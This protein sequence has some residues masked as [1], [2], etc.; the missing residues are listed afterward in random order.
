[1]KVSADEIS[2]RARE[3]LALGAALVFLAAAGTFVALSAV[4]LS[5]PAVSAALEAVMTV[6]ALLSIVRLERCFGWS[7]ERRDLLLMAAV[8][9]VWLRDAPLEA[10][11]A[12][13]GINREDASDAVQVAMQ[14]LVVVSFLLAAFTP[15]RRLAASV[16]R[17]VLFSAL[18]VVAIVLLAGALDLVI[19]ARPFA[20]VVHPLHHLK[21]GSSVPEIAWISISSALLVAAAAGLGARASRG[22]AR[23]APFAAAA[24]LM[25]VARLQAVAIPGS[26]SAWVTVGDGLR[27]LAYALVLWGASARYQQALAARLLSSSEVDVDQLEH[28]ASE[29][30]ARERQRLARDL[31]DGLAQ[32]LAVIALHAQQLE[33]RL[34][35]EHPLTIAARRALAR[36]RGAI[37]DLSAAS[38]PS[39]AEALGEVADELR[40]SYAVRVELELD[41]QLGELDPLLPGD[42]REHLVRIMREAIV[43]AVKHGDARRVQVQL[44]HASQCLRLAVA[45]DGHGI[46]DRHVGAADGFG[47]VMMRARARMLDGELRVGRRGGGGTELQLLLPLPAGFAAPEA[48]RGTQPEAAAPLDSAGGR[49]DGGASQGAQ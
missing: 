36:S 39:L 33:S 48:E 26:V 14:A 22:E 13:A 18:G 28:A 5:D 45:D 31:H 17:P 42:A 3:G 11:P 8:V 38:A 35:R 21:L 15:R 29:A 47:M 12:L 25:A 20:Q 49:S 7:R 32:D 44:A 46:P 19:G 41:P 37:V 24:L 2:T 6:L 4:H 10:L 30:A 23:L 1:M 40:R 9:A 16:R 43:N 34:G 27:L